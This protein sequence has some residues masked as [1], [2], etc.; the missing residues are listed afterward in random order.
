MC[1][2][3]LGRPPARAAGCGDRYWWRRLPEGSPMFDRNRR[4]FITLL[5]G[6]TTWPL[7]ARSQVAGKLPTIG[8]MGS[9][10]HFSVHGLLLLRGDFVNSAGLRGA[11]SR[12]SIAGRGADLADAQAGDEQPP[13]GACPPVVCMGR[14]AHGHTRVRQIACS[15]ESRCS[16]LISTPPSLRANAPAVSLRCARR[17]PSRR[18]RAPQNRAPLPDIGHHDAAFQGTANAVDERAL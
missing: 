7:A 13:A 18:D 4:E 9:T 1:Y 16:L 5:G 15:E 2:R 6:A 17:V 3:R 8:F 10:L 11:P 12:L 14:S